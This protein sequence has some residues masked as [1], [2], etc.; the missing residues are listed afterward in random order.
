M[1]RYQ[2]ENAHH[3]LSD[4]LGCYVASYRSANRSVRVHL[5]GDTALVAWVTKDSYVPVAEA[6]AFARSVAQDT[7][8][9]GATV[10]RTLYDPDSLGRR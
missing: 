6:Q 5:F 4:Q 8:R 1:E 3:E 7:E 2:D 10:L 9:R